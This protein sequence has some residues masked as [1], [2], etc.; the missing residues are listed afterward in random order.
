MRSRPVNVL[1]TTNSRRLDRRGEHHRLTRVQ[2][3]SLLRRRRRDALHLSVVLR[4]NPV[5]HIHI[6]DRP[7]T[8]VR[9]L[10]GDIHV[11][12]RL[13]LST[14]SGVGV[15]TVD[16]L[17]QLQTIGGR[18]RITRFTGD[19]PTVRRHVGF[20]PKTGI[21][22][23]FFSG[24]LQVL[25]GDLG[26]PAEEEFDLVDVCGPLRD[27]PLGADD[28]PR[29][30]K[31]SVDRGLYRR[32]VLPRSNLPRLDRHLVREPRLVTQRVG[33]VHILVA[34]DGD[35][36]LGRVRI[37]AVARS[38]YELLLHGRDARGVRVPRVLR[39]VHRRCVRVGIVRIRRARRLTVS[40]RRIVVHSPRGLRR[41]DRRGE[42]HGLTR[43]QLLRLLRGRRRDV[44][45]LGVVLRDDLVGHGD[46]V[47]RPAAGVRHLICD[48][49]V[50]TG[51]NGRTGRRVRLV[52]V[53]LLGDDE[54][55]VRLRE[56]VPGVLRGVHRRR[57]RVGIVRVRRARRLTVSLRGIVVHSTR[58]GRRLDRRG[59]GDLLTR[60]QLLRLLRGRRRD[61]LHLGVV[62][63]DDLVGHGDIENRGTPDVL[64]LVRDLHV[65]TGLDGDTGSLI[66][67]VV[68]DLLLDTELSGLRGNRPTALGGGILTVGR[69]VC[70]VEQAVPVR[71]VTGLTLGVLRA[72][73]VQSADDELHLVRVRRSGVNGPIR[74]DDH[75]GGRVRAVDGRLHSRR[76]VAGHH[77]PGLQ[78]G[79]LRE[80]GLVA[81][82]VPAT[83][84]LLSTHRDRVVHRVRSVS[85]ALG[86]LEALV[87]GRLTGR[88]RGDGDTGG[89]V[90]A[91]TTVVRHHD[92][93]PHAPRL[94]A[95]LTGEHGLLLD[96]LRRNRA[97]DLHGEGL[98][99]PGFQL[100]PRRHHVP[101]AL[102]RRRLPV[103]RDSRRLQDT[104]AIRLVEHLR[105]RPRCST[106]VLH[107]DRELR[108]E[109]TV[110]VRDHVL[111]GRRLGHREV[112]DRV[113]GVDRLDDLTAPHIRNLLGRRGH[114]DL[115]PDLVLRRPVENSVI[116]SDAPAVDNLSGKELVILL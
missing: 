48:L 52:A 61:V 40:L 10:I 59:E 78:L 16:L 102:L 69:Q 38:R 104:R 82:G 29:F 12:P 53:D 4:L 42:R 94:P 43:V 51:L 75:A 2:L 108:L 44:L 24:A 89:I 37:V 15:I 93:V 41:L 99:L 21:T 20:V 87:H 113:V 86:G 83:P 79:L 6:E 31:R 58:L 54:L 49:H 8:G 85:V 68:L 105:G 100:D 13:N 98:L 46:V 116:R 112:G 30:L 96:V 57:L 109:G 36:V 103:D 66:G 76:V 91:A 62:L 50:V 106:G 25:R 32:G 71:A 56:C 90:A 64:D 63:R 65:S 35:A 33:A 45:H 14:R 18:H 92:G 5:S 97:A 74:P 60:V 9:H 28:H 101:V 84:S 88:R 19:V 17:H 115:V 1:N 11:R 73:G 81:E 3:R 67:V 80:C 47:H 7:V 34:C 55:V 111:R 26:D 39:R 70:G 27:G 22:L 23:A 114:Q 72:D 95:V 77:L 110:A 107:G